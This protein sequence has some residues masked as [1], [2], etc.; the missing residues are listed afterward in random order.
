M[1]QDRLDKAQRQQANDKAGRNKTDAEFD[2]LIEQ[3]KAKVGAALNHVSATNMNIC[4][5][6]RKRP[7]FEKEYTSGEIDCVSSSN[8]KCVVHQA[9]FKVDGITKFVSD[10]NFEFDNTFNENENS[11]DMYQYSIRDLLPSLFTGGIVTCFAYGQTGSGKTFTV[12]QVTK[13]AINDIFK[14]A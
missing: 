13:Y 6:I 7:L 12:S 11:Q 14:I 1:D 2:L 5:C 9:K 4:L 10:T 8:P 3:H